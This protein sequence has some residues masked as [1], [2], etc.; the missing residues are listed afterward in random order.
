MTRKDQPV[1][2]VKNVNV[3]EPAT[4]SLHEESAPEELTGRASA[5]D[6][7]LTALVRNDT[8]DHFTDG[9]SGGSGDDS[10]VAIENDDDVAAAAEREEPDSE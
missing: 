4:T 2:D 9:F 5:T 3:K 7:D 10:G 8:Q 6:D 1:D